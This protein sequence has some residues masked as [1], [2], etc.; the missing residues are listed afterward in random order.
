MLLSRHT[1][2][3]EVLAL[4]GAIAWISES[5]AQQVTKP[6]IGFLRSTSSRPFEHLVSAFR[7]GLRETGFVEGV[8]VAVGY[9]YADNDLARLPSLVSELGSRRAAVIVGNR[10]AVQAVMAADPTMPVVFAVAEDPVETGLV[11]SLSRPSGNAT[12]VSFFGGAALDVK[13]LEILHEIIP[14]G[15]PIAVLLDVEYGQG[16]RALPSVAAAAR[17]LRRAIIV[18]RSSW[19]ELNA[20]FDDVAR[21]QAGALLVSGSPGFT[22]RQHELVTLAARHGLPASYDQR[23]YVELGGLMSYAADLSGAY[24]Q[25]GIYAGRILKGDKPADLPVALPTKFEL[26]I[27]LRTAR[28]L[29]LMIPPSLLARADEVIE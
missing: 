10:L 23:A 9:R 26:V 6:V 3:R 28:S 20:A 17:S 15:L 24:R 22:S 5:Q 25:V 11:S 19:A 8:N 27:N 2:R 7:D 1:R 21:A 4:L 29:G 14:A 13:R 16:E 12:G 18:V